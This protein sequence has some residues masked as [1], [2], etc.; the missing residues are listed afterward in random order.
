[1]NLTIDEIEA[2]ALRLP[3]GDRAE[4]LERLLLKYE[5]SLE[6]DERVAQVWAEEAERRDLAMES[7]EE[8]EIPAEEVFQRLRSSLG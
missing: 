4:L 7:G 5:H 3:P 8:P 2:E 1:M 6:I